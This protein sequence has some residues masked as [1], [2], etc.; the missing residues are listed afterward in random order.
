M[1]CC[2]LKTSPNNLSHFRS[3][4]LRGEYLLTYNTEIDH[5][6]LAKLVGSV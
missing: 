6:G 1:Q 3:P 5:L 4:I 2:S